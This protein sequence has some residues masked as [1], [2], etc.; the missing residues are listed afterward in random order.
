MKLHTKLILALLSGLVTVIVIAQVLQYTRITGL[1]SHLS[2]ANLQVLKEREEGFAK[3]IFR[4]ISRAVAGSLERGEMEKFAKLLEDQ[5][6]VE[7]LLEFS[8]HNKSGVVTHSS[9]KTFL[10]KTLPQDIQ[11][12]LAKSPEMILK[13]TENAIEIY[14]PEIVNGDCIRCHASW[15]VGEIGGI[16]HFRFSLDSLLKAKYQADEGMAKTKAGIIKNATYTVAAILALLVVSMYFLI[17]KLIAVP[18]KQF[19]DEFNNAADQVDLTANQVSDSAQSLADGS[20]NQSHFLDETASSINEMAGMTR[21]NAENAFAADEL[22]RSAN[23]IVNRTNASMGALMAS[24]EE[25]S[26]ASSETSK[27]IKTIDEI[28]FQTNLLALNAA[29]EAA[30]AGEAGAGFAVV[31]DEV[32][33]LALRAAEAAKITED[34]IQGTV[35]KIDGGTAIVTTANDNFSEVTASAAKV[36][37]LLNEISNASSEQTGRIE[38]TNQAVVDLEKVAQQNAH[39]AEASAHASKEMRHQAGRVKQMTAALLQMLEGAGEKPD[40]R[41]QK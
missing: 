33:N 34:L 13:W 23:D 9:N 28:A 37:A 3:E 21:Q 16:S 32:R 24:M 39:T 19:A 26:Q 29:V 41:N 14:Y 36:A 27:I 2:Q 6:D 35:Q 12:R 18:L 10:S 11:T 4:S 15:K 20:A 7:G 40:V 38:K 31:A 5:Q 22:M 1:V 8:L 25:I 17:K 30:R